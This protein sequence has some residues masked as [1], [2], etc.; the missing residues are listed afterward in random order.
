MYGIRRLLPRTLKN[1]LLNYFLR[2]KYGVKIG[3]R[4]FVDIKT[5]F[6]GHNSLQDNVKLSTSYLGIGTYIAE[7]SVIR[8]AK[9]GRFCAIGSNVK[10]GLGI[11]P[12]GDFVSISPSF[13]SLKKQNGLCFVKEQLFEEHKYID[14]EKKYYCKIGNDV[15]V[16]TNVM[17]MDGVTIGDGAVI[18]GGAVVTK[19]VE[20]YAIVGGVPAKIIKKR[21]ND[22]QIS[23]L[24]NIE[25]W[26]WDI[27]QIRKRAHEFN[28]INTFISK[29]Y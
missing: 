2:Y 21:F 29:G 11:H 12:I 19:N 6:E 18:A 23:E 27:K 9:I 10:T 22:Y 14:N 25:W 1:N 3:K 26:E 28:D 13:Y 5:I 4:C 8:G 7:D 15:W 16:G 24:L 20:P 17:I